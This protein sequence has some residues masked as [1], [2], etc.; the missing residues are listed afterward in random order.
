MA[1]KVVCVFKKLGMKMEKLQ[2]IID[3]EAPTTSENALVIEND[4]LAKCHVDR[5]Y[6]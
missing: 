3:N 4:L 5:M 2:L 6:R 1:E